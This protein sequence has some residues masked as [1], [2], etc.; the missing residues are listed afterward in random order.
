MFIVKFC[1]YA[2]YQ[3]CRINKQKPR[4]EISLAPVVSCEELLRIAIRMNTV[5]MLFD[6][7]ERHATNK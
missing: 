4:R 2:P 7:P 5:E 1:I 6:D 3:L